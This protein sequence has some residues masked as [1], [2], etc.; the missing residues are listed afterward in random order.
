MR[1]PLGSNNRKINNPTLHKTDSSIIVTRARK[2]QSWDP[3]AYALCKHRDAVISFVF[4]WRFQKSCDLPCS[5]VI[6][7]N[8]TDDPHTGRPISHSCTSK[9]CT[10]M[11]PWLTC[12]S[13][14][15][16]N[17]TELC[18]SKRM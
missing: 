14:L 2:G 15:L 9:L 11:S 10:G 12:S 3:L 5:K 17:D 18:M 8:H 4:I 1:S 13:P 6:N 7:H 16:L